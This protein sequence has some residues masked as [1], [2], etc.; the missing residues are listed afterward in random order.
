MTDGNTRAAL[1]ITRSLGKAG[2]Q[3][4]VGAET[5]NSLAG[6]SRYCSSSFVYASPLIDA[7]AAAEQ[8]GRRIRELQAGMLIPVADK[9]LLPVLLFQAQYFEGVKIPLPAL[10][11]VMQ[12]SDKFS[13]FQT[14]QR[15][16]I[17]IPKTVFVNPLPSG[18]VGMENGVEFPV[19][20]KPARSVFEKNG[21]LSL[22]GVAYAYDKKGLLDI[23]QAR[24]YL[25]ENCFLIQERVLGNG[26]G[27]FA[28]LADGKLVAEFSHRRI[29]EKP[30]CGGVSVYS[31]SIP[32]RHDVR[33]YSL[34]LLQELGW[35]GIA[36][37]EFKLDGQTDVPKLMEINGRFWGS[38]Q[39]AIDAGVDF[40][41][42]LVDT[43]SNGT[44]DS[45]TPAY[46]PYIKWRWLL[47]DLDNLLLRCFSAEQ[48]L[49]LP[50][51]YPSRL[52]TML[53]FML[54]FGQRK[55]SYD[56]LRRKDLRPF[57][58]ELVAYVKDLVG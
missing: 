44:A 20:I 42:L 25:R 58:H 10:S 34:S 6:S 15:L 38:L 31:E 27:Y 22:A 55:V 35:S 56:S 36:M 40:P 7:K 26:I 37:V 11:T 19:V 33:K 24:Q 12:A 17:P 32:V 30:P 48:R 9:T 54:D 47:G 16:Q 2:H 53:N 57:L 14:A 3:V 8:I 1:A 50:P 23:I 46:R 43:C 21:Q 4:F 39:L 41:N 51:D 45:T 13:L 5:E 28:L 29:R 49:L 18:L 52:K